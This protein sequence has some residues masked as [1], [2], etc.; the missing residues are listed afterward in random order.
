[1]NECY[2]NKYVKLHNLCLRTKG[3]Y[4]LATK[5]LG[6]GSDSVEEYSEVH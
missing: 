6:V 4:S 2:Y 3:N 1:M 5:I